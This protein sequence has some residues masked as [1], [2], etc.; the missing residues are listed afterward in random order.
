[1]IYFQVNCPFK[2]QLTPNLAHLITWRISCALRARLRGHAG[3]GRRLRV[4]A[5]RNPIRPLCALIQIP[6][7]DRSSARSSSLLFAALRC[8]PLN[9]HMLRP[10]RR[11]L[12]N[13]T[14]CRVW[15]REEPR[16][17]P[18]CQLLL[19]ILKKRREPRLPLY[20]SEVIRSRRLTHKSSLSSAEPSSVYYSHLNSLILWWNL[21]LVFDSSSSENNN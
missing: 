9:K 12:S 21:R 13:Q 17:R 1:M 2:H 3:V 7:R 16:P 6:A 10:S 18:Q 11:P 5:D 15:L 20:C 14:F 19:I 8:F 4:P